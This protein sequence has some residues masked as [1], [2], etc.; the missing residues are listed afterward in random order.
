MTNQKLEQAGSTRH[1]HAD[2]AA[3]ACQ[4]QAAQWRPGHN[5]GAIEPS[6]D[7]P[8]FANDYEDDDDL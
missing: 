5:K 4:P 8:S 1:A 6:E 3:R 7:P 2:P